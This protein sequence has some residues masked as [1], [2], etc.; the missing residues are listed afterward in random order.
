MIYVQSAS[1]VFTT[2]TLESGGGER[3]YPLWVDIVEAAQSVQWAS[4]VVAGS[5]AAVV[6]R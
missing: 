1:N 5:I 3:P 6:L 2:Q 4:L